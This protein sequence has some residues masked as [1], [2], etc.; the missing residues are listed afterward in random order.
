MNER[1][2]RERYEGRLEDEELDDTE[3]EPDPDEVED[4]RDDYTPLRRPRWYPIEYRFPS[5]DPF[6]PSH[7]SDR[8]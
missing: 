7:A 2:W 3:P 8:D 1:E 5:G 4:E 6:H